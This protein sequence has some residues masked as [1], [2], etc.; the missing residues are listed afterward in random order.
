MRS[1]CTIVAR[2]FQ[3]QVKL[4]NLRSDQNSLRALSQQL[5]S[6]RK[7]SRGLS[8]RNVMEKV[9]VRRAKMLRLSQLTGV[10]KLLT[11]IR[12]IIRSSTSRDKIWSSITRRSNWNLALNKL[13]SKAFSRF[14]T[15][16]VAGK[17]QAIQLQAHR[18]SVVKSKSMSAT[19]VCTNS[20]P[21]SANST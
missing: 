6:T 13:S 9:K 5:N 1:K 16:S 21:F 19:C 11:V 14:A 18:L 17:I 3:P 2:Q 15:N 10:K 7:G 20:I 8:R 4:L 12:G